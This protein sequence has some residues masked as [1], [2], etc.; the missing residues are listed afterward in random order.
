MG[1]PRGTVEEVAIEV[2]E[3]IARDV[4]TR[5]ISTKAVLATPNYGG[6]DYWRVLVRIEPPD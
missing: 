5:P 3:E 4:G 1:L 6:R 2:A